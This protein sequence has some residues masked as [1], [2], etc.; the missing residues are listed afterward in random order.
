MF[1]SR[2]GEWL[3][4]RTA[5]PAYWG[6]GRRRG[7]ERP[8]AWG[9][10]AATNAANRPR[11]PTQEK[12]KKKQR[13]ARFGLPAPVDKEEEA[14]KRKL[15]E[16]RF[17]AASAGMQGRGLGRE[18]GGGGPAGRPCRLQPGRVPCYRLVHGVWCAGAGALA[19][20]PPHAPGAAGTTEEIRDKLKARAER[21]GLPLAK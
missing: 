19:L 3:F 16:Q 13:A 15:R 5:C 8:E 10:P 18:G 6:E 1:H 14:L 4:G 7:G 12:E 21:F 17:K 11:G 20:R 2:A 9:A